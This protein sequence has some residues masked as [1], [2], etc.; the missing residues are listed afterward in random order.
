MDTGDVEVVYTHCCGVDVHKRSVTTCIIVPGTSGQPTKEILTFG[1][2]T[3][4]ITRLIEKLTTSGVSHVAMESTGSYWKPIWNM[5]EGKFNLLLVNAREVKALPGRKTD[6]KDCEWIARLMRCGLLPNSFVPDRAQRE[7]RELTRY[8]TSLIQE[9]TAEVNRLQKVLEGANIKLGSVATNV[10]GLSGRQILE[11]LLSGST[12]VAAMAD[13]AKG[14]LREKIPQLQEALEGSFG[15]HQ[16]FIVAKQL[17]HIDFLDESIDALDE[18]IAQ[19]LRPFDEVIERLDA[20]TGIGRRAAEII[21]AEIGTD[22]SRFPTA[23]H[24]ASWAGM[25]PGNNESAGKRRSGKTKKGNRE[26]RRILVQAGHAA[27]R[28]KD[29]QLGVQF[30][31]LAARRGAKRAAVAVGHSILVIIYN[32]VK[33]GT[34]YCDLG[35]NYYDHRHRQSLERR[36]VSGL[37]A[38]GYKVILEPEQE[39]DNQRPEATAA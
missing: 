5:L 4:E 34:T 19:R 23:K 21:L 1:T 16:R 6:V 24:L 25:S 10:V 33:N 37:K 11:Q 36:V 17:A 20:I 15:A 13:L 38:L 28:S 8:R 18:E 3:R 2:T 9:R 12:D 7:L 14:R 30:G 32:M 26:L 22:M 31:R 35:A 39:P 29:T 27:G